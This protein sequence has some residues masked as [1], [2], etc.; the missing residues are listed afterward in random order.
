[1]SCTDSELTAVP[2]ARRDELRARRASRRKLL[3]AAA[4]EVFVVH[5]YHAATMEEIARHAGFSK[6]TLYKQF[7]SKLE[8][9]LAVLQTHLD[10]L[11]AGVRAA[12]R[13]TTDNRQRVRAAVG[14]YF[15]FIDRDTQG[16]RLI[17]ESDITSE[18]AV[19][20][21]TG[22]AV[23]ACVTAVSEIIARDSGV[24]RQHARALAV[25]LVGAS[26]HGARHW[27]DSGRSL[28]K[29]A[30]VQIT[31]DLCWGGLSSVPQRHAEARAR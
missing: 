20:W 7:S 18:P 29:A 17:F 13:S 5:G 11:V 15:D 1:M 31:A 28:S 3:L 14:S 4:D 27:L 12:L 30:A 25:G 24:D 23:D 19:Q 10:A 26:Q 16:Y 8:L 2:Y 6:P 22:R 9:Y 21:H